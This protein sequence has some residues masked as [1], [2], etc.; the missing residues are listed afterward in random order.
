MNSTR[1]LLVRHGQTDWNRAG[2]WQ[3]LADRPL[4]QAGRDQARAA[5]EELGAE[6]ETETRAGR[7]GF[8]R[9]WTSDLA[10]A[11]ETAEIIARRL[12]LETCVDLRLRELDVG[13][14][15]GRP[16]AEIHARDAE[17]LIAFEEGDIEIRA[18]GGESRSELGLRVHAFVRD[19]AADS[20]GARLIV[21]THL[22]VI[23]ALAPGAEPTNAE[24]IEVLAEKIL[25]REAEA[26]RR[27]EEC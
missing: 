2:L 16:R 8:D 6:L 13:D 3:G 11:G 15:S 14:W 10:R 5:A 27:S 25:N 23:R 22:G 18:G 21:V 19:R 20:A 12:D 7:A 17:R 9:I 26:A 1:L 24:R 4:T